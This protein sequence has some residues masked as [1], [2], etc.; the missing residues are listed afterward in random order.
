MALPVAAL[1]LVTLGAAAA[2]GGSQYLKAKK[3]KKTGE[4]GP[5]ADSETDPVGVKMKSPY[6]DDA[7]LPGTRQERKNP[8][9]AIKSPA[10]APRKSKTAAAFDTPTVS[11]NA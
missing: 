7:E 8:R 6:K 10:K 3:A 4:S 11:E 5:F 1:S 2:F 9:K